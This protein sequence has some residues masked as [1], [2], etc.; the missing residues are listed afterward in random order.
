MEITKL[1]TQLATHLSHPRMCFPPSEQFSADISILTENCKKTTQPPNCKKKCDVT[2]K[3]QKKAMWPA[4]CKKK[5]W[6]GQTAKKMQCD[7]HSAKKK[8]CERQ[9]V[10]KKEMGRAKRKKKRWNGQSAK[11]MQL[12]SLL[13]LAFG[14]GS[15]QDET[16]KPRLAALFFLVCVSLCVDL[17]TP[18]LLKQGSGQHDVSNTQFFFTCQHKTPQMHDWHFFFSSLWEKKK[19]TH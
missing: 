19:G 10:K 9:S 14:K 4:K 15:Q 16:T 7:R 5:R 8:R 12:G 2:D 13:C 18:L 17:H 11:K 1:A 6:N 3:V